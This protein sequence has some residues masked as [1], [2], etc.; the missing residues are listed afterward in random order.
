M[1][2]YRWEQTFLLKIFLPSKLFMRLLSVK[3]QKGWPANGFQM[4]NA[5]TQE[6]TLRGM[7]IWAAK[8]ILKRRKKVPWKKESLLTL[9]FLIK[10]FMTIDGKRCLDNFGFSNLH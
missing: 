3:M 4:E 6:E 1:D 9:S 8:Q 2:G 10:T 7:T 5:L